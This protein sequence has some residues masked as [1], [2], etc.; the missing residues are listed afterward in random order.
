MH[1]FET[2]DRKAVR[3]FR[4]AQFNGRAATFQ[5]HDNVVTGIVRSIV[6]HKSVVPARWTITIIPN[7]PRER[8]AVT[9][10][11]RLPPVLSEL[12]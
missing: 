7:P 12:Y 2:S 9:H 3:R 6:E 4:I 10:G 8:T 11:R 5:S 1:K